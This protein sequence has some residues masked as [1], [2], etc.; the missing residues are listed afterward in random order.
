MAKAELQA[1]IAELNLSVKSE[2]VPWS[3]SRNA[4]PVPIKMSDRSLNWR[5]TLCIGEREILST[6]YSAGIAHCPSYDRKTSRYNPT[7]DFSEKIAHETETGRRATGFKTAIEP[8]ACDVIS[9]LAMDSEAIDYANFED[10][11]SNY[12]YD[13]ADSRSAEKTYRAC[14]EIGLKLNNALGS[15]GLGRLR[16][17]AQDY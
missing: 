9:S 4:K 8:D 17:A 16:E 7:L 5:V 11:A 2:F 14:L 12:G 13:E 15:N 10:W 3:K 1:V 6:D